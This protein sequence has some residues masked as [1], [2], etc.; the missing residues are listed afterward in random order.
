MELAV[1]M[2]IQ[3]LLFEAVKENNMHCLKLKSFPPEQER[4]GEFET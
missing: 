3:K 2:Q 1:S 4:D